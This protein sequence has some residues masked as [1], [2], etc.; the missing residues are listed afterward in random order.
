M[1]FYVPK[2]QRIKIAENDITCYKIVE[3]CSNTKT[4]R[5]Q[6][7]GF[8]YNFKE[9]YKIK[10]EFPQYKKVDL[11]T[12]SKRVIDKGFHSYIEMSYSHRSHFPSNFTKIVECIIPKGSK[13]HVNEEMNEYVSESIK[14][15]KLL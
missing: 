14:I 2:R 7:L 1:C 9:T 12:K 3:V 5:S 11:I 4:L 15:I 6:F 8:F 13:Y 10:K